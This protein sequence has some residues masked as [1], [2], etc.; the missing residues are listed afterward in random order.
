MKLAFYMLQY[1][2]FFSFLFLNISSYACLFELK[3][4]VL[5]SSYIISWIV[6][7]HYETDGKLGCGWFQ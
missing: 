4:Q 2:Q 5:W 6:S 7:N 1:Y 3:A